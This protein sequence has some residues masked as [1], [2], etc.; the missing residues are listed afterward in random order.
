M[1][2]VMLE[3]EPAQLS[4]YESAEPRPFT[5]RSHGW[6]V[7]RHGRLW[8]PPTDVY[9]TPDALIVRIEIAGMHEDDFSISLSTRHLVIQGIRPDVSERRAYHRMEISFGEFLCE[10]ELHLPVILD[11]VQA[12]YERG[13]LRVVLPK[14]RAQRIHV[15]DVD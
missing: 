9:E 15:E 6:Q 5:T 12:E 7:G 1:V 13:F 4:G 10:V 8:R 3:S 2:K 14:Q 11:Q